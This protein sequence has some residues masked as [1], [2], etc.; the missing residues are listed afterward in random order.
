MIVSLLILFNYFIGIYYL[1]INMIYASLIIL[2]LYVSLTYIIKIRASKYPQY[3]SSRKFLP[4][5]IIIPVYNEEEYIIDTVSSTLNLKYPEYEIIVVNDGSTDNSLSLLIDEFK[6][7][8][9]DIFYRKF[10]DTQDVK[11]FYFSEKFPNLIVVDKVQGGKADALNCGINVSKYPY[12]CSLD[13]DSIL[14]KEALLRIM[15][16]IALSPVPVVATSG[17]VRILNDVIIDK[18]YNIIART[19]KNILVNF[20]IVE[21]LNGFLFGRV[22]LNFLGINLILSGAFSM[23]KKDFVIMVGG[24]SKK[25]IAEDM[26]IVVKL[27]KFC[28]EQNIPYKITMIDDTVCWTMV[29]ERFGD[30]YKQ[31][32]RW[33]IGLM[34]TLFS[35]KSLLFNPNYRSIGLLGMPYYFLF[36]F[37]GP[38]LEF[39]SYIVVP[40]SYLLG[41]L[42]TKF[43]VVFL[44][45]A[46]VFGMLVSVSGILLEEF[47][48]KRYPRW[49]DLIKLIIFALFY[50][51]GYRQLNS[52]IKF[53]SSILFFISKKRNW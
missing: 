19:S 47:T 17:I 6:L 34:Q 45:L 32:K 16:N 29:P 28:L 21:Y 13:A 2:S 38:I 24:Y 31:R 27:H 9:V 26:E 49:K 14:E 42:S 12:F 48:Y 1:V 39:L 50:N 18:N 23:F 15:Y 52:F 40:V 8:K 7:K 44:L 10:I 41:I 43:F 22:G 51:L 53:A 37:L 25:N 5:S 30:F 33:H 35:Y 4:V 36:E 46:I 20:Q 11:A 3:V